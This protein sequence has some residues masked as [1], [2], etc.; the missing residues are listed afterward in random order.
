MAREISSGKDDL[1][2]SHLPYCSKLISIFKSMLET[3]FSQSYTYYLCI[4][5]LDIDYR[6]FSFYCVAALRLH[7]RIPF[8]ELTVPAVIMGNV[9]SA[10]LM[11]HPPR[12]I[13]STMNPLVMRDV[14]GTRYSLSETRHYAYT[15][16]H[17]GAY[18]G[19]IALA[20]FLLVFCSLLVGLTLAVCGL[21]MT[22]L[23]LRS[24]TGPVKQRYSLCLFVMF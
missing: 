16:Y 1:G 6:Y 22:L 8:Y 19:M 15:V 10:Y 21:D 2:M 11:L 13:Y 5:F 18:Y 24:I 20:S 4:I 12:N 23:H 9:Y 14:S 3:F 7:G 17:N